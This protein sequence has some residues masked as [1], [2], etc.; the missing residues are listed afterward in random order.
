M[1]TSLSN[2]HV[3]GVPPTPYTYAR[4]GM[5]QCTCPSFRGDIGQLVHGITMETIQ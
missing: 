4:H 2:G 3:A 5:A 1:M